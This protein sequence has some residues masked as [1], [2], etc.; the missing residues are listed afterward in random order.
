MRMERKGPDT[1]E[2]ARFCYSTPQLRYIL[3]PPAWMRAWRVR[4]ALA[5]YPLYKPPYW[6]KPIVVLPRE[7]CDETRQYILDHIPTRIEVLRTFVGSFGVDIGL[8]DVG[9]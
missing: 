3:R 1:W 8:D 4:K 2:R 6:A 7:R 9:L 5:N